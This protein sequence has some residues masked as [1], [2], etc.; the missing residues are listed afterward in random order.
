MLIEADDESLEEFTE[1]QLNSYLHGAKILMKNHN[2]PHIKGIR[3]C[4]LCSNKS[5]LDPGE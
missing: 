3:K 1:G 4:F 5:K 2:K